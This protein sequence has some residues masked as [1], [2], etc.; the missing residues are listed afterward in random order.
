MN[1]A[2]Y[3]LTLS[4]KTQADNGLL[5]WTGWPSFYWFRDQYERPGPK[6]KVKNKSEVNTPNSVEHSALQ[7]SPFRYSID[8]QLIRPRALFSKKTSLSSWT[9]DAFYRQVVSILTY[10]LC[11][12]S[13]VYNTFMDSKDN[14]VANLSSQF[15]CWQQ[16][17]L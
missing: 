7:V 17:I 15:H 12:I 1:P 16:G 4:R 11:A 6:E 2:F 9:S 8:L 13:N 3:L 14:T 5:P 10:L